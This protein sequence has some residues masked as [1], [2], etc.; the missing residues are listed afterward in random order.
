MLSEREVALVIR[1]KNM[2]ARAFKAVT[3]S[4]T[5][6]AKVGKKAAR[7][8]TAGFKAVRKAIR[9][10]A[11]A[12][13]AALKAM[14]IPLAV[15]GLGFIAAVRQAGSFQQSMANVASVL[16]SS[17]KEMRRLSDAAREMGKTSVFNAQEAASAMY[18]LASA[19]FSADQVI[20][21][22]KGT[23]MLAAA[24]ASDLT[25]TT[26]AVTATSSHTMG[27]ATTRT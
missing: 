5:R 20:D 17:E 11:G 22:L 12:F 26:E 4:M 25:F 18:D 27:G 13:K 8:L 1:A 3:T 6:T 15:L 23:M 2:T 10:V 16:G 7:I 9:A 21:A 24:T 14:I 19:G